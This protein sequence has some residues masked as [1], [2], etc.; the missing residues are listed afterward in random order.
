LTK[1]KEELKYQAFSLIHNQL[2]LSP[3]KTAKICNC[4]V[5]TVKNALA[6]LYPIKMFIAFKT[7]TTPEISGQTLSEEI[8]GRFG[9]SVGRTTLNDFRNS[10]SFKYGSY[11]YQFFSLMLRKIKEFNFADGSRKAVSNISRSFYRRKMH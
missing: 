10:V 5:S 6:K 9:V 1:C 4:S 11:V 3:A 2:K 8:S 7:L